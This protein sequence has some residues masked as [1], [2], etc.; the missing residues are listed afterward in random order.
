MQ[1]VTGTNLAG[2]TGTNIAGVTGTNILW[3][4]RH[5]PQLTSVLCNDA[6]D[7]S[8]AR[9]LMIYLQWH[10]CGRFSHEIRHCNPTLQFLAQNAQFWMSNL[11]VTIALSFLHAGS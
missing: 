10:P 1:G 5:E 7:M 11:E 3:C 6:R 8:D 2:V 9:R 4:H